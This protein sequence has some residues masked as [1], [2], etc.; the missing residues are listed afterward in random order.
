M[1]RNVC[2]GS[3][4][5]GVGLLDTC[6][7]NANRYVRYHFGEYTKT[8]LTNYFARLGLGRSD[9]PGYSKFSTAMPVQIADLHGRTYRGRRVRER[10]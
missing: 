10:P 4:V 8:G 7:V 6:S 9:I 5:K 2:F 1:I 3:N